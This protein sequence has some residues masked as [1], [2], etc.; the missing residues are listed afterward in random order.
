MD[1]QN[2]SNIYGIPNGIYYGQFERTE[3]LNNRIQ[4]RNFPDKQLQMNFDPRPVATKYSLFPIIDRR[5]IPNENITKLDTYNLHENF[6][7][8]NSRAPPSG[9]LHNIEIENNLR[10][11]YF[12]LQH[13]AEQSVYVP[14]SNSDLYKVNVVSRPS[15]QPHPDLF[16][17]PELVGR[18]YTNV[19]N[20]NIGNDTFF[21]HT[22]T[23][24]RNT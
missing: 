23:Q 12:A 6:Y 2:N 4:D 13:G 11:Q 18:T 3:E 14:S 24:L 7:P 22:R 1:I 9:Y 20:T 17:K 16:T 10:N 21:N 19:E 5:T 8:G 15:I